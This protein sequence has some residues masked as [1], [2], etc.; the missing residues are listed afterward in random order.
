MPAA[1]LFGKWD[2]F[3]GFRSFKIACPRGIIGHCT[4]HI[5]KPFFTDRCG[6]S[7]FVAFNNNII[8]GVVKIYFRHVFT[9]KASTI[10]MII[11]VFFCY[12]FSPL[13]YVYGISIWKIKSMEYDFEGNSKAVTYLEYF[14]VFF[15]IV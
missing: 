2:S 11:C 9:K 6:F 12:R 1:L 15:G 3:T 5:I 13:S 8:K 10:T 7:I 4:D 14:F